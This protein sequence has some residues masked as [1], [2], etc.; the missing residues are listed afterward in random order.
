[1]YYI[2]FYF[3]NSLIIYNVVVIKYEKQDQKGRAAF[4]ERIPYHRTT[5]K[6]PS[7]T[8]N[9]TGHMGKNNVKTGNHRI[10]YQNVS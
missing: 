4:N 6:E 1:M 5:G 7:R 9:R 10:H 2:E 8:P 3:K